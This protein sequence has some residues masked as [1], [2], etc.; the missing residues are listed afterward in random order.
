MVQA[1]VE[2]FRWTRHSFHVAALAG[3]FGEARVRLE[4]G[5][6]VERVSPKDPRHASC[7]VRLATLLIRR[8]PPTF[9]IRS[10]QPWAMDDLHEPE[11]D[12]AVVQGGDY[13]TDHP[14][15]AETRLLVE[16]SSTTRQKD[17]ERVGDYARAG[18]PEA[19]LIDL[20]ARRVD[21]FTD[22]D[23]D[24]GSWRHQRTLGEHDPLTVEGVS[25]TLADI[26]PR[27]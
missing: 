21:I 10:E 7:V 18:V 3:A 5:E 15:P 22:P 4:H 14:G 26:A 12:L 8:L 9:D 25:F 27:P 24:T 23:P 16:V 13:V 19:W 1:E 20:N 6:V 2:P 11:P 17:L